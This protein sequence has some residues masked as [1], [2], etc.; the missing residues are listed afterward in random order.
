MYIIHEELH[1]PEDIL[2][3]NRKLMEAGYD[4]LTKR[5]WNHIYEYNPRNGHQ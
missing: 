5:G 3:T 1:D 2:V 4:L